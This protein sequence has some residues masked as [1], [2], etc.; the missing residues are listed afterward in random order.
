MTR[1]YCMLAA[2]PM[3]APCQGSRQTTCGK[4]RKRNMV[5]RWVYVCSVL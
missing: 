4:R 1:L 5:L 3:T 2:R